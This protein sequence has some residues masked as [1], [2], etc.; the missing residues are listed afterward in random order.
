[1]LANVS[2][3]SGPTKLPDVLGIIARAKGS[4]DAVCTSNEISQVGQFVCN[5]DA[6]RHHEKGIIAYAQRSV[7]F[8]MEFLESIREE[9]CAGM[10]AFGTVMEMEAS[11]ETQRTL[12]AATFLMQ[13]MERMAHRL[14]G[15]YAKLARYSVFQPAMER[16]PARARWNILKRKIRDGSFFALATQASME[17]MSAF[18]GQR[19]PDGV[20]FDQVIH[21]IQASLDSAPVATPRKMTLNE[22]HAARVE[23]TANGGSSYE[24]HQHG[25]AIKAISSFMDNNKRAIRRLSKIPQ[26]INLEQ[27]MQT[28]GSMPQAMNGLPTPPSSRSSSR[29]PSTNMRMPMP[30][31]RRNTTNASQQMTTHQRTRTATSD[32]SMNSPPGHISPAATL[33]SLMTKMNSRP[34][35]GSTGL[36][37]PPQ[38]ANELADRVR[39]IQSFNNQRPGLSVDTGHTRAR[40]TTGSLR[41]F[42]LQASAMAGGMTRRSD[43]GQM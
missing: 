11:S 43:A 28:Y 15:F 9:A 39:S 8:D 34:R 4:N 18:R 14:E 36:P 22:Q 7:E 13:V 16:N 37:S 23:S 35:N 19:L 29:S 32:S 38:S 20:E 6:A 24:Q 26:A 27:L 5:S 3:T 30:L 41:S 21:H 1:M 2:S 42:R 12:A 10:D 31:S 33:Q 40:S 25:S 17:S